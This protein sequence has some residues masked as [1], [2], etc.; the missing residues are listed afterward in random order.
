MTAN[1]LLIPPKAGARIVLRC[2]GSGY[3][4]LEACGPQKQASSAAMWLSVDRPTVTR[5][6]P[7]TMTPHV[8]CGAVQ[9][10]E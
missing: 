3:S 2:C 1:V 10:R 7:E 8:S 4:K 6:R 5:G 9:P